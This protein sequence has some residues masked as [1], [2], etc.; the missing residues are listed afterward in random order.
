MRAAQ[1][2]VELLVA[3]ATALP[4]KLVELITAL[5]L[6]LRATVV[7]VL[8]MFVVARVCV[9]PLLRAIDD[10][11]LTRK[12]SES[13]T[14]SEDWL[15]VLRVR[16]EPRRQLGRRSAA[17]PPAAPSNGPEGGNGTGAGPG[18]RRE[19]PEDDAGDDPP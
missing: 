6:W 13:I 5:P 14:R 3:V 8:V 1:N 15:E 17:E 12:A 10:H 4:E 7:V 16:N 9:P 19:G 2:S 18:P 11:M